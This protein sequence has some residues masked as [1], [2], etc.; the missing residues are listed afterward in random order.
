MTAADFRRIALSLEGVEEVSP[1]GI[2]SLSCRG[3]EICLP[4]LA[5][6]GLRKPDTYA[7]AA[8]GL[9][10][11][12]A[13]DFPAHSGRVGKDGTYPYSPRRGE[14]G[15]TDRRIADRVETADRDERKDTRQA[16]PCA[17]R[18]GVANNKRG[19]R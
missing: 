15:C 18:G 7:G 8:G 10:G 3:Q 1:R 6:G 17:A 16:R 11:R 19:K 13:R 12:G 4:G 9:R 5:S 14:P 2:A